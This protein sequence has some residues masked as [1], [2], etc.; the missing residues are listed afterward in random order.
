MVDIRQTEP[1]GNLKDFL[2]VVSYIYRD[3]PAFVRPLDMDLKDR[4]NPKK[5]PF[6]EHGEA[7]IF[8]AH[9]NGQCVGRIT[10][11]IDREHLDRYKDDTG[12]WGFIDTVDD[13]EIVKALIHRAEDWLKKK[14]MKHARGPVSLSVNEEMGCLVDGFDTPPYIMMPHH[15]PY[16]GGL[17]E[18]AG[19]A[20]IKDLLAWT[21]T[22]GDLPVRVKKA[23]ADVAAMPEVTSRPLSYKT[24]EKD[25]EL[26]VDIFNDAWS[27]NWAFVPL[28][29][30]EVKK[31]SQ[32]FKMIAIPDLTRIVYIDGEAA[33]VA[34]AIPNLNDL[35]KDMNGSLFPLGLP[36][37][38]WRL[39]V[40]GP[41]TAR[42]IILGIRKKYRH[43]R[44]YAALSLFLYAELNLEGRKIGMKGGEFGWTLEDN[45]AVNAGIRV[46]GAKAYKKYRVFT[47]D[48][49]GA[50]S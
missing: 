39:K 16:Q 15:R 46:M 37:L 20:K 12:F 3:D 49:G 44:K 27:D 34:V 43:V 4:L 13:A 40:E 28:T 32:D 11:S 45:G 41:K 47:R 21:Y 48:L 2:D 14:G 50:P 29:R 23:H 38:L 42:V 19:Y 35:V 22:V 1:G 5:N 24:M 33:A 25:V 18:Q 10:A 6:F 8:T 26:V 31:M 30:A 17:I 9:K 7:V 36:K